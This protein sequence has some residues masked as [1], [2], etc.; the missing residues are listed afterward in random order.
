MASTRDAVDTIKG[1]Y[2][3]FNYSILRILEGQDD[4]IVTIEG[5]EDVDVA[6]GDETVAIQ[7]KY[8]S[9]TEYNH[10]II[11]KPI[12]FMFK[13]FMERTKKGNYISY[14]LYGT[15]DAGQS[16]LSLPLTIN[17]VKDKFLTY[18]ET[19]KGAEKITHVLHNE[20]GAT[21]VQIETF[22]AKLTIDIWAKSYEDLEETIM[23]KIADLFSCNKIEAELYYY[24]NALRAIKELATKE[25]EEER[26]ISR[27]KFIHEI[28][29]K[30]MLFDNWYLQF[31]GL[32]EFC[33]KIRAEFFT[34]DNVSPVERY[35]LVECDKKIENLDIIK[36]I[37]KIRE[38]W[39]KLAQR[40]PTPFCPY[41][42]LQGIAE[43][44]LIE[45][46]KCLTKQG[47]VLCDGY[48]FLGAEFNPESF[49]R[50]PDYRNGIKVKIANRID[51]IQSSLQTQR[52]KE[53][54]VYQFYLTKPYF[55]TK[56]GIVY[57]IQIPSTESIIKMV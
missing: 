18:T 42:A 56:E 53:K 36:L 28:D 26:R 25:T 55:E 50:T 39:S 32:N 5:I 29:N 13:D 44:R 7:C 8:Y 17:F 33:K 22:I 34:K 4:D 9:K 52:K 38:N 2:Y 14:K 30:K 20:L 12:R 49:N 47:I 10:S 3:Q 48:D 51:D 31:R 57:N 46:K 15:Y 35:F 43:E 1:Y 24:N 19:K 23:N 16:K 6:S 45:I 54:E 40:E 37:S 27:R 21:D 41:I 11:A